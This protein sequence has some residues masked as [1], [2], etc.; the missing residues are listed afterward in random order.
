RRAT[1]CLLRTGQEGVMQGW[2]PAGVLSSGRYGHTATLLHSGLVLINGGA[3]GATSVPTAELYNPDTNEYLTRSPSLGRV[4]H[5]AT[6][7]PDGNVL[8]VGGVSGGTS[9]VDTQI[10]DRST[11]TWS[12]TGPLNVARSPHAATELADGRVLVVGGG[13]LESGISA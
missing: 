6:L 5:T 9:V 13:T 11:Q 8:V 12:F 1:G 10:Y 7:L 4:G 3:E 2:Q